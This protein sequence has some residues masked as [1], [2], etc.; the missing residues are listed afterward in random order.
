MAN[1]VTME[2]LQTIM[3]QMMA[4]K[5]EPGTANTLVDY[6][7]TMWNK[8]PALREAS[9]KR[10]ASNKS[11]PTII[12]ALLLYC[13]PSQ[14]QEE[15]FD[16]N[17]QHCHD[18]SI[19]GAV[20]FKNEDCEKCQTEFEKEC[21][22]ITR[23]VCDQVPTTSCQLVP[24]TKCE[25]YMEAAKYNETIVTPDSE[26]VPWECQNVTVEEIHIKLMPQCVNVT[27]QDCVTKWI[28]SPTGEKIWD[29]NEQCTPI[30]WRNCTLIEVPKLFNQ[31]YTKCERSG[32]PVPTM[33]CELEEK[34]RMITGMRC[35][36]SV[37]VDCNSTNTE[38]CV[39]I[40]YQECREMPKPLSCQT[41]NLRVPFQPKIHRVKCLL[42]D[43]KDAPSLD[44]EDSAD[45]ADAKLNTVDQLEGR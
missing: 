14:A 27:R 20:A 35:E 43:I 2:D 44:V 26:Y 5:L 45:A 7:I 19:W 25:M 23:N 18:V 13:H 6:R 34:T 33:K 17:A 12:I 3:Q 39:D 10:M 11:L 32:M 22:S 40:T 15:L 30:Q 41:T 24:Y 4:A 1:P 31:T 37:A 38:E 36:V 42:Q 28:I 9:T 29:G 8:F 16:H 21:Q